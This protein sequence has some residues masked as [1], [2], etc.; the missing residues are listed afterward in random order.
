MSKRP[1]PHRESA[2]QIEGNSVKRPRGISTE[3][4]RD[5]LGEMRAGRNPGFLVSQ[6][7]RTVDRHF[8][9]AFENGLKTRIPVSQYCE[10]IVRR[11]RL[12]EDLSVKKLLFMTMLCTCPEIKEYYANNCP[13]KKFEPWF[14]MLRD[15][16]D[17]LLIGAHR[18]EG[19]KCVRNTDAKFRSVSAFVG[20]MIARYVNF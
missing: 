9:S 20:I 6:D 17:T 15:S 1:N 12:T 7:F 2:K 4:D 14:A 16:L 10:D 5:E 18:N 8:S 3:G 19:Q 11:A 13:P